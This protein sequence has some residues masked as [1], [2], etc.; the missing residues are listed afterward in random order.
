MAAENLQTEAMNLSQ[1]LR[2]IMQLH[3]VLAGRKISSPAAIEGSLRSEWL[4]PEDTVVAITPGHKKRLQRV[5]VM[6]GTMLE[7]S[8]NDVDRFCTPPDRFEQANLFKAKGIQSGNGELEG[9]QVEAIALG[10]A[11][12]TGAPY[13]NGVIIP[14]NELSL[15]AFRI[16]ELAF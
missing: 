10:E 1:F 5:K 4:M 2:T 7:A 9:M 13:A 11:A 14:G 16:V 8:G 12:A 6:G 15:T 3:Q